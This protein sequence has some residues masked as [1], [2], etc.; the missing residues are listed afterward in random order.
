MNT[1]KFL[2]LG[3]MVLV[4]SCQDD[5]EPGK[6]NVVFTHTV[7]GEILEL[8]PD[9]LIYVNERGN[10]YKIVSLKYYISKLTLHKS[11]GTGYDV[12]MYKLFNLSQHPSGKVNYQF[13]QIPDGTYTEVSFVFGIDTVRNV[14]LGLGNNPADNDMG[15]P[16]VLG[17]G[18]HFMMMDGVF[19]RENGSNSGFGIHLGKTPN[20]VYIKL[21]NLNIQVSENST[22]EVN[23]KVALDQWFNGVNK[24]DLNDGYGAIMED[25]AKQLLFLQ[26]APQVFSI[27]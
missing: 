14:L 3:L 26:N 16:H 2:L 18:Y 20:Q 22:T 25:Q 12:N 8:A 21:K 23:I 17:G 24:I 27:E 1:I 13:E 9:S 15:W 5:P 10:L 7:D 4:I 6:V 19:K 11:D